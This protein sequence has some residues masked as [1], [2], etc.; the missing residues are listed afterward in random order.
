MH[1]WREVMRR[2]DASGA[3]VDEFCAR[4]A[5]SV[6]SFYR[7]RARV[8]SAGEVAPVAHLRAVKSPSVQPTAAGFIDLGKLGNPSRDCVEGLNVRLDLGGGV[9]LQIVRR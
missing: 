7:W 3:S 4:E 5:V 8:G 2:F 6:S 9:V 1:A